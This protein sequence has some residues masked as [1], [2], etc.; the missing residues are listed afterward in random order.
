MAKKYS[1]VGVDG[2]AF[3][4]MGYVKRAME[5]SG[6]SREEQKEFITKATSGDYTN[7]LCVAV[8]KIEECN[9]RNGVE[10]YE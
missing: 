3:F 1:L 4:V 8:E 5:E 6:F 7:L 10:D 9:K 2:N